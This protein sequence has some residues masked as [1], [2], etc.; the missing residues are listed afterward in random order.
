ML[1]PLR[2][3]LTTANTAKP[4]RAQRCDLCVN[5]APFAVKANHSEHNTAPSAPL[6]L[7]L[8]TA[9]ITRGR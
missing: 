6:R 9:N 1:R 4:Q 8:T 5:A 2:L 7:K 3:K